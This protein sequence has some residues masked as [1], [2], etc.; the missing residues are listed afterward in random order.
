[1]KAIYIT[2]H[3]NATVRVN[4][5]ADR[6]MDRPTKNKTKKNNYM[7]QN[8]RLRD[9]KRGEISTTTEGKVQKYNP[10]NRKTP[11]EQSLI[12]KCNEINI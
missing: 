5:L 12:T 10:T 1:M 3:S 6:Q 8:L 7:P 9:I 2:F 4:V 11:T